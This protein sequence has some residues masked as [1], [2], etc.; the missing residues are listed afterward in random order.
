VATNEGRIMS[1]PVNLGPRINSPG[2]EIAPYILDGSLYFASDVFYGL[3]GMDV[4]KSRIRPGGQ[5]SIPVNLGPGINTR[6]DEFGFIL[7]QAATEGFE[8]YFTSNRPG[9]LGGDDIY[10]FRTATR[11]GLKTRVF[12]G[13]VVD[14]RGNP[15]EKAAVRIKNPADGVLKTVYTQ[16]DGRFYAELPWR[17][18]LA[19][20]IRKERHASKYYGEN[21]AMQISQSAE[22][23][24]F[25]LAP[26][27][28][29]VQEKEGRYLL[30]ADRF[31]FERG[32][33]ELNP[34]ARDVLDEVVE[35][36]KGFPG[37]RLRLE[38]HTDS[39]GAASTNLRLSQSRASAIR[40]YLVAGGIP[41]SQIPEVEGFGE[42][43]IQNNCTD[44]VYCLEMLHQQNERYPL[45]ILNYEEL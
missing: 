30:K 19:L 22:P 11:P 39:R 40:E 36:L 32:S 9:G 23:L 5:Y 13:L 25:S 33:S 28:D 24:E 20:E 16:E 35:T 44:G 45:V 26:L 4:Y 34:Q 27:E 2:N 15:L 43:R 21:E 3:G 14:S 41:E 42:S 38:A 1:A 10:G 6:H 31:L 7:R 8:G 18:A 37:L 12:Q 17:E 29:L